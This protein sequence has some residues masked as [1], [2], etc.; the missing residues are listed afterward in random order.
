MRRL[1]ALVAALVFV[2]AACSGG[3]GGNNQAKSKEG[4]E[5]EQAVQ[6]AGGDFCTLSA[7]LDKLDDLGSSALTDDQVAEIKD[8]IEALF[9]AM[10]D[11]L[12]SK[13]D[14]DL[15]RRQVDAFL[16][17]MDATGGNLAA[18][19]TPEQQKKLDEIEEEFADLQERQDEIDADQ[20]EVNSYLETECG[21]DQDGDGDTDGEVEP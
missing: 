17:Y 20:A 5:V 7:N 11:E 16:A 18:E 15:F 1:F 14:L 12:K 13:I 10:P 2:L 21:Q 19:P 4:K 9:A 3:G 8:A 6:S